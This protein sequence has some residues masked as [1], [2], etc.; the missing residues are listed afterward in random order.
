MPRGRPRGRPRIRSVV[1]EIWDSEHFLN[2]SL[3]GRE[4]FRYLCGMCDDEGLIRTSPSHLKLNAC[5]NV[6]VSLGEIQEQWDLMCVQR[7]ILPYEYGIESFVWVVNFVVHQQLDRPSPSNLPRPPWGLVENLIEVLS[8]KPQ[9]QR[10]LASWGA[11]N[12]SANNREE[13]RGIE[14]IRVS[15]RQDRDMEEYSPTGGIHMSAAAENASNRDYSPNNSATPVEPQLPSLAP[16]TI[17][18]Q[19]SEVFDTWVKAA[20]KD[21]GRV[22]FKGKR[23]D[24]VVRA[25]VGKSGKGGWGPYPLAELKLAAVGWRHFPH[26]R[27]DDGQAYHDLELLCRDPIHIEKFRDAEQAYLAGK[28][29]EPPAP[30]GTGP[31]ATAAAVATPPQANGT[32]AAN[33]RMRA[34]LMADAARE[35]TG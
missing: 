30:W 18:Q 1:P 31:A 15:S 25:L 20:R 19:A 7:M 35:S 11:P 17:E 22:E 28:L 32:W 29:P 14:D 3:A 5:K 9:Q 10:L 26:N 16:P 24:A 27:G 2:L 4:C 6:I 12:Y 13:T 21:P 33:Q 23:H 8:L 34:A